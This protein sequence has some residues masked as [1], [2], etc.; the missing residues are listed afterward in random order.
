[1]KPILVN[2]K[3]TVEGLVKFEREFSEKHGPFV[4]FGFLWPEYYAHNDSSINPYVAAAAPWSYTRLWSSE[5][6]KAVRESFHRGVAQVMEI[7]SWFRKPDS[8]L[9]D[10]SHQTLEPVLEVLE[11]EHG[12]VEL[13]NVELLGQEMR[14]AYI[15]TS[16]R[17]S[18]TAVE[19]QD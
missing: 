2:H 9:L 12:L 7:E 5:D 13:L 14:R 8:T 6:H 17:L 11:I 4:F 1:M 19:G 15:I 10:P 3:P 18:P 16:Q